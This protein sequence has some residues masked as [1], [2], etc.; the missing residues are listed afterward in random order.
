[1]KKIIQCLILILALNIFSSADLFS[2]NDY[3]RSIASGN[4]NSTSTWEM[5]VNNVTWIPATSTPDA[6]SNL[7]T[8]RYP[9]LV[10]ITADV[11]ADQL[12]IDSGSISINNGIVFTV[13]D[14]SGT[15][16][17]V[18]K[19]GTVSGPG[20]F[21]TQGAGTSMNIR[22]GS[23]FNA[24]L[25]VNSGTTTVTELSSPFTGRVYGSV[26]VDIGAELKTG[27]SSVYTLE[28]YGNVINN[29][30]ISGTGATFALRAPSL[31]N[32]GNISS[33]KFEM[34]STSAIS[35][36]GTFTSASILVNSTGNISILNNIT[37]SPVTG[38]SILTGGIF[39]PNSNTFT[40][41]SG[42]MVIFPGATISNSGL[43][44]TQ[45]TVSLN[46]RNGS[47]FNAPLKINT[48]TTT[49]NDQSSPYTGRIYNNVTV[50]N[51][52]ILFTGS[53]SAFSLEVYGNVINNGTISG[54]GANFVFR[55]PSLV[56]NNSITASN[57]KMDSTSTISGAGSFTSNT[58]TITGSSNISLSS[59]VTFTPGASFSVNSGGTLNPNSYTFTLNSGTFVLFSGATVTASGLFRTQGTVSLNL[60]NN[61]GFNADLKVNTGITT[62]NELS[63]PFRG[64]LFGSVTVDAGADLF[65]GP[66]SPYSLEVYGNL[67][68]NGTISGNG[69]TFIMR[70]PSFTNNS[71]VTSDNL[72]FNST[73]NLS[74]AGTFT[75]TN[76]FIDTFAVVTLLSNITVA[77]VT[78]FQMNNGSI[79]NPNSF[80]FTVTSG[81]FDLNSGATISNSG[82]FRT[83]NTV[84][85]NIKNGSFFNAP[86]RVA[87]GTTT[88]NDLSTPFIGRLYGTVTINSGASLYVGTSSAYSLEVYNTLTNNGDITGAFGTELIFAGTAQ[89]FTGTGSCQVKA[90]ILNGTTL[91]M[92][93]NHNMYSVD[94]NTGGTFNISNYKV[95]FSASDPIIQNGTFI[96]SNSTVEYNGTSIQNISTAN[97]TYHRL[98]I[99]NAAYTNLQ[100][101]L[102]VNDTLSIVLGDMNIANKILTL[103]PN[104][105]LTETPGN[106]VVATTGYVKT[107]RI[108]NAPSALNVAGM[109][110]VITTAVNL[111]STEIRR[112]NAVQNGLNG[113]TSIA[114]YF[115]I[116]PA[117]NDGLDASMTFKYDDSELNGKPES[118]LKLFY[119]TNTG[120]TWIL[121]G[122][123]PNAAAN[124]I[125]VSK[126]NSFS[127]WSADTSS[128]SMVLNYAMEGFYNSISK[129]LNMRDTVRA[130]LRSTI[131]PYGVA[132]SSK[133]VVDSVTFSAAY[134]FT[135]AVNGTYYIQTR[136][137]NSIETWSRSGGEVY[138]VG[139]T[140]SYNFTSSASKAFGNNQIQVDASPV[141]YAVYA[142]DV[143][144][145]G[146]VDLTD[147][148][149]IDNDFFNFVSGYVPTDV[150]GD[151][152][153]DLADAVF[154][155][156]N[157]FNFVGKITP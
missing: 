113:G 108:L 5:S 19:G 124:S 107:T 149:L 40:F 80:F 127:R 151:G 26:T 87:S 84:S 81:R 31:A 105:Y 121:A 68:N 50:D 74:G 17:T 133:T 115:D 132:D 39:N 58:V 118:S 49:A 134:N 43:V 56:N 106:T 1:M 24:A 44:Q 21:R 128:V 22:S 148:S 142:G 110:A 85:L 3:F 51:G 150:N 6:A 18:L 93:S 86:L 111:G 102:T 146:T 67:I 155:D 9:N 120:S 42:I 60:R 97:I 157:G 122:G 37:F 45:N 92:G 53:S 126:I 90:V 109:G 117:V 138:N 38:F 2:A 82:T 11:S 145:D 25:N 48:G 15:D 55:G 137:R 136:H 10:T 36:N 8:V 77:P 16:F 71:S 75:S 89:S 41:N 139:N 62:A 27:T 20:T 65:T 101:N 13:L 61:S 99:N 103:G 78:S 52:A 47:N 130:Y 79:L 66:S 54:T 46:L 4:W 33:G 131:S 119:S 147:G 156:N 14:G 32:N 70:G 69:A 96:V 135:N 28:A 88:A 59:N 153:V 141:R 12:T 112:G 116:M 83:Q 7:I 57:L 98:K 29:G 100:A 143:N 104:A 154:T 72:R 114:R 34:D 91:T 125:S 63:S 129:R 64:R 95:A 35:G 76:I 144:Q 73:S 152:I 140:L 23:F 123:N 30:T 94:I